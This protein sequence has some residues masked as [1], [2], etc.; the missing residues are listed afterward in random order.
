MAP[1]PQQVPPTATNHAYQPQQFQT[2]ELNFGGIQQQQQQ[3][4]PQQSYG[5]PNQTPPQQIRQAPTPEPK[6][7]QPLPEE[8]VYL[9]TVFEELRIQCIDQANNAVIIFVFNNCDSFFY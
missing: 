9:Q 1:T 5:G 6:P 7:K 8:Y 2:Q 4:Q 3:Q